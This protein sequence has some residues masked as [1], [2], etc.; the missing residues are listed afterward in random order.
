M[1]NLQL[2]SSLIGV[3]AFLHDIGK[4]YQR[5]GNKLPDK[6]SRN[7]YERQLILNR[8]SHLHALYTAAFFDDFIEGTTIYHLWKESFPDVSMQ[9]ASSGHHNPDD[10]LTKIIANADQIAS[11]FDRERYEERQQ[12]GKKDYRKV[13]LAP[14]LKHITL[15]S[16]SYNADY[17]YKLESLSTSSIFPVPKEEVTNINA[18]DNY[19]K[20]IEKFEKDYKKISNSYSIKNYINGLQSIFEKHFSFVPSSTWDEYDEISLYD[21]SKTTAAFASATYNYMVEKDIEDAKNLKHDEERFLLIRGEFF[22]IQKFIFGSTSE[23]NKNPAKVLRGKS[24]YVTMLSEIAGQYCLNVLNLPTFNLLL[25]AAGMFVILAPNTDKSKQE[26][27]RLKK[28]INDWLYNSFFGEVSF[29]IATTTATSDDF[30]EKRF[31]KLWLELLTELEK[32]KY[33]KFDLPSK[34]AVF[35]NY[36][37]GFD[38]GTLCKTCGKNVA[39]EDECEFCLDFKEI[40]KQLV[41]NRFIYLMSKSKGKIFNKFDLMFSDKFEDKEGIEKIIDLSPNKEFL[42]AYVTYINNYVPKK[43]GEPKSFEDMVSVE[44]KSEKKPLGV[45]KADVDNLG[46]IFAVGLEPHKHEAEMNYRLTFSRLSALSRMMNIFFSYYLPKLCEK[47]F[48]EIYTVFAGGDDLF[49][50]G[51]FDQIIEL[52]FVINEEFKRFTGYNSEITLS[53]GISIFKHSTPVA[54]M[55]EETED[56]LMLAKGKSGDMFNKGYMTLFNAS[57]KPEEFKKMSDDFDKIFGEDTKEIDL[58]SN[59]SFLY[60]I[61]SL[62]DMRIK[63]NDS[64]KPNLQ[65]IMWLPRLKYLLARTIKND[66]KREK[67][68]TFLHNA[69]NEKPE[70]FRAIIT[71]NI[72]YKRYGG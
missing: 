32:E 61:L 6:Y 48:P 11:G 3:A 59:S 46:A 29:G 67:I 58:S 65:N 43:G 71:K 16:E 56:K 41:N 21:H 60:K 14:L 52:Y 27:S 69:I 33:S 13:H 18:E 50:I 19:R 62:L 25:N 30:S 38:D 5:T 64:S 24:F 23:S 42:G 66:E 70:L 7:S 57:I 39:L 17:R 36:Y 8:D 72:Y 54:Y 51:P 45:I 28:E 47:E 2:E 35:E 63:L 53:A 15:Q 55:A 20:L 1:E 22:G 31:E 34:P 40:G 4:V 49:L 26:I 9:K 68:A 12:K 10:Y 44:G 37:K